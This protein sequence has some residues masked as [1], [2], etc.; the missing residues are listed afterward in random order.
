M[1]SIRFQVSAILVLLASLI[2]LLPANRQSAGE[3][4]VHGM[5][6]AMNDPG[7]YLSV[8][9]VARMVVY[10]DTSILLVDVRDP[11]AY[12]VVHIPGAINI[13]VFDILNPDWSGYLNDPAVKPVFYSNGNTMASEAWMICTQK[14]YTGSMIMLGGMNEWFREVMESTFKGER[15]S[16]VENATFEVR[17]RAR[18][19]FNR[20]NSMPDSLKTAFLEVKRKKEAELVG[21]CE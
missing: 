1:F 18:D 7:Q 6:E 12:R 19:F 2:I 17:Y 5:L 20:M 3:H 8:D 13:P 16:A 4:N 10:E 21:G 14:G 11:D 9:Q 15:I